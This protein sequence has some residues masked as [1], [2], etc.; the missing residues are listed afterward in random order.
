M[1]VGFLID[2]WQPDR[3]G[4]ERAMADLAT[5]L[6]ERG[7][8]P[9]AFAMLGTGAFDAVRAPFALTRGRRERALGHALVAAARKAGCDVTVGI[10]H[11]PRVDLY[12]PHAGSHAAALRGS[13][14]AR[15]GRLLAPQ[16]VRAGGRHRTFL[17][18]ERGLLEGGGARRIACVSNL[19]LRELAAAYPTAAERL[20]HVPNGVDTDRFHPR[21]R[22]GRGAQLRRELEIDRAMPLL[23]FSARRPELKGLPTVF[24]ALDGLQGRPWRL[25]VAGP[26]DVRAWEE[27][28][29]A[30]GLPPER[31]RVVAEVDPV[32]LASACDLLLHPTWRDACGLVV[33]EA[34]AAGTP[35]V[36]TAQAGAAE[37]VTSEEHGI[38]VHD[39]GNVAALRSAI[40][41]RLARITSGSSD[42]EQVRSA[43]LGR[44]RATWLSAIESILLDLA[45]RRVV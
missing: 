30:S 36:T 1:R 17:E 42:R 6:E 10:R 11:L 40:I 14:S 12:W 22:E 4:A 27:R 9:R 29:R 15:E 28:A 25:L 2:R 31:I 5:W 26:S 19:V 16:E 32:A 38:V 43:I 3:G 34:L 7:H 20:V 8:E 39:P 37:V 18:M 33:L 35:V 24:G 44:D 41:D 21:E 45:A 23:G 13:Q